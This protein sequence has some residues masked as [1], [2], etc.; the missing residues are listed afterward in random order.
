MIEI[1]TVEPKDCESKDMT[2]PETL[3]LA[4]VGLLASRTWLAHVA[5]R[6]EADGYALKI[7][8]GC[9]NSITD[10]LCEL[11]N[12][13][14]DFRAGPK[15][16]TVC[17]H[18]LGEHLGYGPCEMTGCACQ[19]YTAPPPPSYPTQAPD[20]IKDEGGV[21][22]MPPPKDGRAT[23]DDSPGDDG[24]VTL[25]PAPAQQAAREDG[26]PLGPH[27]FSKPWKPQDA[28]APSAVLPPEAKS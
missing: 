26:W 21:Q 10:V 2:F 5:T 8:K 12:L 19:I 9:Q 6:I 20:A 14:D 25:T 13:A 17:G 16:C 18:K 4:H 22:P 1:A 3:D 24:A 27:P 7:L 11:E 28:P 15:V 23:P